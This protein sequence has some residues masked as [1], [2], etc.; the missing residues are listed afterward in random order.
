MSHEKHA[1]LVAILAGVP[2]LVV[3]AG[4]AWASDLALPVRLLLVGVPAAALV[5]GAVRV[6]RRVRDPLQ[7][8]ASL[9]QGL[10]EGNYSVRARPGGD[11]AI[12]QVWG[13]LNQLADVLQHRRLTEVETSALLASVMAELDV[14]VLAIDGHGRLRLANPA[15]ARLFG[16]PVT[17]LLGR[18]AETLDCADLLTVTGPRIVT[19]NFPRA[20]GRW[21]VRRTSFRQE[22][23]SHQLLVLSDV[24]IALRE[25]ERQAWRR[26]I[27]VISHELNN[28]LTPIK[29]IAASLAQM[30]A[31]QGSVPADDLSRGLGVI[32]KR[33]DSL[34]RFLHGYAV[35]AKLPPPRVSSVDL[36][37]LVARV[38]QLEPQAPLTIRP[39]PRVE[40][41]ADPDQLEQL[42]INLAR[43]GLDAVQGRRDGQTD[44]AARP[45][46]GVWIEWTVDAGASLVEVRV[47]DDGPGIRE[48]ADVFV[49][50]FTTKPG[51]SGIGLVL[52]RQIADAHGGSVALAN[53]PTGGCVATVRLPLRQSQA[54]APSAAVPTAARR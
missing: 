15:A 51:G 47:E 29:S 46:T 45:G 23:L 40:I 36:G 39:S 53:R 1:A 52:C 54:R 42:L 37:T 9:L 48:G 3:A 12:G 4:L 50:F 16:E 17:D 38:V 32:G 44:G 18:S 21:E 6:H 31:R 33:A 24:S 11:D 10:R 5:A 19:L 41:E 8:V 22:G 49:P 43:N 7:T 35:L 25:E 13:E 2:A 27:R 26:L 28:S 14:A 20:T 30:L 34:N